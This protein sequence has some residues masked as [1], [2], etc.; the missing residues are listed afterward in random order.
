MPSAYGQTEKRI[1]R[2]GRPKG[3]TTATVMLSVMSF[4]IPPHLKAALLAYATLHHQSVS[5][6]IREAIR[7]YLSQSGVE[8]WR[9]PP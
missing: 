5:F 2:R 4:K 3:T 1:A 6:V 9:H 8:P 7:R